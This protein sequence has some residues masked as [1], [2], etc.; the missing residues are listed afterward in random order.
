MPG[1][2]L[3]E[4]PLMGIVYLL[5]PLLWLHGYATGGDADRAVLAFLPG[6]AGGTLM[7]SVWHHRLRPAGLLSPALV[8][9]IAATWFLVTSMTALRHGA[10]RMTACAVAVGLVVRLQL[11]VPRFFSGSGRRF[12]GVTLTRI[13]PLYVLFAGLLCLW[14]WHGD[15]GA[16]FTST[17]RVTPFYPG[18][19]ELPTQAQILSELT[20]LATAT[21]GGYVLAESMGRRP[22]DGRRPGR[23]ARRDRQRRSVRGRARVPRGPRGERAA[24]PGVGIVRRVRCHDLRAAARRRQAAGAGAHRGARGTVDASG[25]RCDRVRPVGVRIGIRPASGAS[26]ARAIARLTAGPREAAGRVTP[27]PPPGSISNARVPPDA[28]PASPVAASVSPLRAVLSGLAMGTADAVPG[29]SGGTIALI[30][31]IYERLI[32]ALHDGTSVVRRP[33]DGESWRRLAGSLRFLL[34]L[35]AGIGAAYWAATRLLVGEVPR[36]APGEEAEHAGRLLADPPPG[37]LLRADTA[38]IVFAFFFGLVVASIPEPWRAK[39][40]HKGVDWLVALAGAALAAALSVSSPAA[41]S[42]T[43]WALVAAGAVAVSVMLLP[44]V[45]GSLALLVLG[46]YQPISGALHSREWEVLAWV[47]LGLVTGVALFVPLLRLLLDRAHDRTMS[48]LSGLMAG[49]L[50]ALWPWKTHYLPKLIEW[51]GA[52]RPTAPF[53]SWW[54]PVLAAVLGG[55][56][57]VAMSRYSR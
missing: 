25:R 26:R 14:P 42:T 17:F 11:Y 6:L 52:M 54:W 40:G 4:L 13:V 23:H 24:L 57:I 29:V 37:W 51:L 32:G 33:L 12:E 43:P 7:A 16:L 46:M 45:S 50:V 27:V 15:G 1:A 5:T 30:L 31:G 53:G 10:L 28:E 22:G 9:C 21:L 38:P 47:A 39:R 19:S 41:G 35:L 44:G 2:P 34:P 55:A 49:S 18:L 8:A 20:F 3:L 48:F 56:L 36:A